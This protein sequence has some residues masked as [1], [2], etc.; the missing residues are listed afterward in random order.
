MGM[1]WLREAWRQT[2]LCTHRRKTAPQIRQ[3]QEKVPG[4]H[5]NRAPRRAGAGEQRAAR[6]RQDKC[7]GAAREGSEPWA[8]L[9]DTEE[10][11]KWELSQEG[12]PGKGPFL[13]EPPEFGSWWEDRRKGFSLPAPRAP[14]IESKACLETQPPRPSG[15]GVLL[16]DLQ[17]PT[18]N[19][20]YPWSSI[21]R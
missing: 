3:G 6:A 5:R 21:H 15:A 13:G 14:L 9:P 16:A 11:E 1:E 20:F 18:W 10:G 4:V 19:S 2:Q 7:P 12:L 17:R 8:L